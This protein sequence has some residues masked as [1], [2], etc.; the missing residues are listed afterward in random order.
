MPSL[1]VGRL[2]DLGY[3]RMPMAIASAVLVVATLLV[4]ECTQY[5]H[6][7]LCQGVAVGIA[8]GTIFGPAISVTSHWFKKKRGL[9]LGVMA[10]GSS[11]GG[12]VFPIAFNR[13]LPLVGFK[14][15]M[16][17]L[18]FILLA[19]LMVPNLVSSILNIIELI[20]INVCIDDATTTASYQCQRR[21]G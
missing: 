8:A 9:A 6:F 5:W 12:T 19:V 4:A 2:F 16:R 15:T 18:A 1:V 20:D 14:W 7:I 21:F 3:F 10:V 13:L 11:I 17:I